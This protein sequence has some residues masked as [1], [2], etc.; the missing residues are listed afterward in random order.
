MKFGGT[1]VQDAEAFAR[2]AAIVTGER[3]NSPVVVTSAMSKVT[4]ALLS[5]FE[6]ARKGEVENA[7]LSLDPHFE[8][9]KAV[10]R[11]LT[12]EAA[13]QQRSVWELSSL[14]AL[15]AVTRLPENLRWL[16][17]SAALATR[18]TGEIFAGALLGHYRDAL[19]EIHETGYLKYLVREYRPYLRAAVLQFSPK[20]V[21][22]TERVL[23][24]SSWRPAPSP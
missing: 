9:H 7:I 13:R 18:R 24:R 11:E 15:G 3:E 2:V 8:R 21:S 14:M 19:K 1:S 4:D 5:A 20:H 23:R 17:K 16:G 12:S 6:M 10:S 22:L